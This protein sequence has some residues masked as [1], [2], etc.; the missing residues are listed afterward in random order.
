VTRSSGAGGYTYDARFFDYVQA[1]AIRSARAIVPIIVDALASRSV[2]DVG[3]GTGAWLSVYRDRGVA[4]VLGVDGEYVANDRLLIPAPFFQAIDVSRPF[5]LGRKFDLVQSL[6]VA[7]HIHPNASRTIIANLTHHSSHVLFSAAVP[8]QGG[9][10]HIN[11]RTYEFWR[12]L[13]AS[14]G[15]VAFD[16]VRP[17]V[18]PEDHVEPWYAYNSILYVHRDS[19]GSLPDHVR[20]TRVP[21]G[22][23]IANVASAFFRLRTALL[24]P[25]PVSI[26]SRLA[27]LN[28]RLTLARRSG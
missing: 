26:V 7:E 27:A 17:R 6:E 9:E 14:F 18:R 16:F 10:H 12:E 11:E 21:D 5:D 24:R 28:R 8:G 23:P 4:D 15:F 2:L 13:F 3:C 25:L 19:I 20:K 22:L 1:G